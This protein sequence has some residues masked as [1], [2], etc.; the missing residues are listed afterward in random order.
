[1]E[2]AKQLSY[3]EKVTSHNINLMRQLVRNGPD[4]HP[5]A[6]FVEPK[7]TP[8]IKKSMRYVHRERMANELKQGDIIERYV[9]RSFFIF[10]MYVVVI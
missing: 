1:M 7:S 10:Y 5:G 8:G 6:L 2:V 3:P 9:L 4:V